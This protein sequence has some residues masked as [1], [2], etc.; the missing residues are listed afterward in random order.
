ML[1]LV[2]NTVLD[3]V[4]LKRGSSS[5]PSPTNLKNIIALVIPTCL[6]VS[7]E[8]ERGRVHGNILARML[9]KQVK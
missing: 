2:D 9:R 7:R 3:T 1:E 4:A 6:S 5:L 8:Q